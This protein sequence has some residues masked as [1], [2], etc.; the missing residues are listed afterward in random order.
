MSDSF[1]EVTSVSWFGRIGQSFIGMLVGLVLVVAMVVL[2]F[3]NEGRAV[4]TA[5]SLAE[6]A[7]LV[8]SVPSDTIEPGNDGKLVHVQGRAVST[9][10]PADQDLGIVATGGL[11]LFRNVEM[12]Q[13]VEKS[14]SETKTK[15]GGGEET[16]TTY[17]YARDWSDTPV[18]SGRFKKPDGHS[19]PDMT[20]RSQRFQVSSATLGA[21]TLDREVIDDIGGRRDLALQRDAADAVK[22]AYQGKARVSVVDGR[23]YLGRDPT[24]P[25]I[26]DYR[27][28]YDVVP[29][30]DISIV[31]RQQGSGFAPYQTAAGDTLLMVDT[32]L[33]PA[34]QMF[35]EAVTGN[36]IF[37]WVLRA[38][39]LVVLFIGFLLTM[40]IVGVVADIIPFLGGIV[41]LGTGI[42]AFVLA[43]VVGFVTIGIAWVWYRPLVT[44]GLLAVAALAVYLT[45]RAGR[46]RSP[47][48]TAPEFGRRPASGA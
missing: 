1:R 17:T 8:V 7:G 11:R 20:I 33:V 21:F 47:A 41:R 34:D 19:N 10:T 32:G 43:L 39:G 26:G 44:V 24:Q 29:A 36:T 37:T 2:L 40:R 14:Q 5:K 42:V 15:L 25:S 16:V 35:A 12:Y 45:S 31:A 30:G 46:N 9:E 27:I 38:V 3:W 6:G 18:D 4:T 23:I 48:A 28:A 13:W 22:A